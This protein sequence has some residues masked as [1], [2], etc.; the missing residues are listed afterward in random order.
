MHQCPIFCFGDDLVK[1]LPVEID[2]HARFQT[3]IVAHFWIKTF[4]FTFI[5][6][7]IE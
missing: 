1:S 2:R 4:P 7:P 5:H 6:L 3:V